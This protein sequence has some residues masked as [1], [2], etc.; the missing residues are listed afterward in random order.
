LPDAERD[1]AADLDLAVEVARE[2]GKLSLEWLKK[3][4]KSWDK[5]PGNVVTEADIAV[6][7]LIAKRLR[8]VRPGYG[9][10][11]EETKDDPA[12]RTQARTWVVDP[13]DGTK[14]FVRGEP[15]FSISIAGLEGDRSVVA[16]LFNPLTNEMFAAAKGMGATLNGE[17]IFAPPTCAVSG[18]GMILRPEIHARLSAH[19]KWPET[20]V[21]KP[22]PNSVAYRIAL[23]AS[24]RW[25][26]AIVMQQTN[27][28]DIAAA[29]LILAEAGGIASDGEG[30]PFV[31]N[32]EIT[33]H[34]GV[35][36]AGATLHPLL[37]DRLREMG[38]PS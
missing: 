18:C 27:D 19:P 20:R 34:P 1:L 23:V 8:A 15:G 26:A 6:N 30:R 12:N 11:S 9:W 37:M 31:F 36:A 38:R 5:S 32:R 13:I 3:G 28:W 21:L 10:L 25:D 22:M 29:V 16:A 2:A 24:G 14:A 33:R 17:R 4:A 35:V 7:E